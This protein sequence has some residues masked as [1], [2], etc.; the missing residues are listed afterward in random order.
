L[1]KLCTF[2]ISVGCTEGSGPESPILLALRVG[3]FRLADLLPIHG[4]TNRLQECREALFAGQWAIL[5]KLLSASQ[6]LSVDGLL[7]DLCSLP[8]FQW[9][10]AGVSS[11]KEA[12][13]CLIQNGGNLKHVDDRKTTLLIA[14][15]KSGNTELADIIFQQLAEEITPDIV[16]YGLQPQ[17][18]P[19]QRKEYLRFLDKFNDDGEN[20][21]SESIRSGN[22]T[23]TSKLLHLEVAVEWK[24][25][26]H[27]ISA[28]QVACQT[29]SYLDTFKTIEKLLDRT[30]RHL[31]VE[32]ERGNTILHYLAFGIHG[33]N[34][35]N[36][37]DGVLKNPHAGCLVNKRN[38]ENQTPLQFAV[39]GGSLDNVKYLLTKG[40]KVG[41]SDVR[42][43]TALHVATDD[44]GESNYDILSAIV[45]H[46]E[47]DVVNAQDIWGRT[48]LMHAAG[49]LPPRDRNCHQMEDVN[50]KDYGKAI[51]L[52]LG[53]GASVRI[54]DNYHQNV[55]HHYYGQ[56]AE[57]EVLGYISS[58]N[59]CVNQSDVRFRPCDDPVRWQV[60]SQW[61]QT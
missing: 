28:L 41:I 60:Q 37:M 23:M 45:D 24:L 12:L 25:D 61:P 5:D 20:A 49:K 26:G 54:C 18:R 36:A 53:K 57:N 10:I 55:L 30:P 16:S 3:N 38:K 13:E 19:L 50:G 27:Q 42:G 31:D 9:E 34:T 7:M 40:A 32:D 8:R 48:A 33:S 35:K 39:A 43:Y 22:E 11:L 47:E 29:L 4:P 2:L 17:L 56:R 52:L 58:G 1:I 14:A 21:I 59:F 6:T 44:Y 46:C 15:L 51:Q